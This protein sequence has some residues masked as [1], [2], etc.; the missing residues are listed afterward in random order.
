LSWAE[1]GHA[2][3]SF[4]LGIELGDATPTDKIFACPP[5]FSP[6]GPSDATP[7]DK[8]F[9][10]EPMLSPMQCASSKPPLAVPSRG[11]ADISPFDASRHEA[12]CIILDIVHVTEESIDPSGKV[13]YGQWITQAFQKLVAPA[14]PAPCVPW[15]LELQP[16]KHAPE[17][18][19]ALI[20]CCKELSDSVL[21]R[22]LPFF[23]AP[24][25]NDSM[26]VLFSKCCQFCCRE[27]VVNTLPRYLV[28][29]G[30]ELIGSFVE[31]KDVD[32]DIIDAAFRRFRQIDGTVLCSRVPV[33]WRHFMETDFAVNHHAIH[34][35]LQSFL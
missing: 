11:L 14:A 12:Q 20:E 10:I 23:F 24:V 31:R 25:L 7:K 21:R 26:N 15:S 30:A 28:L 3:P 18:I 29:T 19:D 2:P 27:W 6:G 33:R 22:Y 32:S 34:A 16:C 13:L 9:A 17:Q 5:I 8:I 4:D 35:F 1:I